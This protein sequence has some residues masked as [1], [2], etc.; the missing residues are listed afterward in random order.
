MASVVEGHLA[1]RI[2]H[3]FHFRAKTRFNRCEHGFVSGSVG[4]R[5]VGR[6]HPA[7]QLLQRR[8]D[9][10]NAR[11]LDWQRKA[12][13]RIGFQRGGVPG[14]VVD[15]R[16]SPDRF[17]RLR[18]V[19]EE[20]CVVS[21]AKDGAATCSVAGADLGELFA[22]N[23]ERDALLAP[24]RQTTRHRLDRCDGREQPTC[25]GIQQGPACLL[26]IVLSVQKTT[27][28]ENLA[29]FGI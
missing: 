24:R 4:E 9:H 13:E 3:H 17:H 15:K 7:N 10:F 8:R 21:G 16:K 22:R 14:S 27:S 2:T 11:K 25:G 18:R 28:K 1:Q 29:K 5:H 26:P 23:K 20:V 19:D 6:Q 12:A